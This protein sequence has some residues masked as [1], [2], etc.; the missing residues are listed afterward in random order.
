MTDLFSV[1]PIEQA[2]RR[3]R[4]PGI[5]WLGGDLARKR[6]PRWWQPAA[7]ALVLALIPGAYLVYREAQLR[8]FQSAPSC[9]RV[10]SDNCWYGVDAIVLRV[11]YSETL[12]TTYLSVN[13]DSPADRPIR[14]EEPSPLLDQIDTGD[15]VGVEIWHGQVWSV[16]YGDT[17]E[18]TSAAVRFIAGAFLLMLALLILALILLVR[19]QWLRRTRYPMR[20]LYLTWMTF[21]VTTATLFAIFAPVTLIGT[22]PGTIW[23][24]AWPLLSVAAGLSLIVFIVVAIRFWQ[25]RTV[26]GD[27]AAEPGAEPELARLHRPAR[28]A[29]NLD[30]QERWNRYTR[31]I[32]GTAIV[33]ATI[34]ALAAY[35]HVKG[36]LDAYSST[37]ACPSG[38]GQYDCRYDSM[39]FVVSAHVTSGGGASQSINLGSGR[40]VNMSGNA[41]SFVA[42]LHGGDPVAV[43]YWRGRI[44]RAG[45]PTPS[46][47]TTDHP[48]SELR[49]TEFAAVAGLAVS[50]FMFMVMAVRRRRAR[51]STRNPRWWRIDVPIA[52]L[53]V[54]ADALLIAHEVS[55]VAVATVAV[56][57]MVATAYAPVSWIWLATAPRGSAG[58]RTA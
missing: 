29:R 20:V 10:H 52:V 45:Y 5:G 51:A 15:Q 2:R 18:Y 30:R 13:A 43:E 22:N 35:P 33:G 14:F 9:G 47:T 42:H 23:T 53:V 11:T 58:A 55:G 50:M 34:I 32:L 57:T 12:E 1:D 54:A 28:R 19:P 4:R 8:A 41:R 40:H 17:T 56:V 36:L 46:F 16:R 38:T 37:P 39:D 7:I 24:V 44:V 21:T 3:G 6:R 49:L 31:V 48:A 27:S 26:L 25:A